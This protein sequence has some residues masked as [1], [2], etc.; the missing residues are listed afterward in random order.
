VG[1]KED[2]DHYFAHRPTPTDEDI[3]YFVY[4]T[5]AIEHGL[6]DAACGKTISQEEIRSRTRSK[7][8]TQPAT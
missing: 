1:T 2:R 3:E 4:V 8:G 7:W 5:D 6:A